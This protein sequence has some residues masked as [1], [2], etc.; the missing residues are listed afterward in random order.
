MQ[1]DAPLNTHAASC[2]RTIGSR[3]STNKA[4][5]LPNP[6]TTTEDP[7]RRGRAL[8]SGSRRIA[9]VQLAMLCDDLDRA[10]LARH[11]CIFVGGGVRR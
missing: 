5:C 1:S 6:R 7:P 4:D 9:L 10:R 3:R 11:T 2:V 8:R